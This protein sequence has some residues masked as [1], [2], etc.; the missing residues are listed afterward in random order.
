MAILFMA[1]FLAPHGGGRKAAWPNMNGRQQRRSAS[2]HHD[3][4]ICHISIGTWAIGLR[5]RANRHEAAGDW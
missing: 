2:A 5:P 3:H 4:A 1:G